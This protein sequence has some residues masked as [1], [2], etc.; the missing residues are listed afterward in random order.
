LLLP[1]PQF[2]GVN[3]INA[4]WG[5]SNYQAM[6]VTLNKRPTH[7]ISFLVAYTWSKW[8]SNVPNEEAQIGAANTNSVQD[9]GN[10]PAEYSLSETDQ[11]LNLVANTIVRLPFGKDAYFLHDLHGL[12]NKLVS[13]WNASAIVL[14][15]SGYPLAFSASTPGLGNRPNLVPNVNPMLPS[16]RSNIQKTQEWFNTAA[17]AIPAPYTLGNMRR[18][19]GDARGPALRNMDFTL[20]KDTAIT[21]RWSMQFRAEAF[22]LTN[23]PHFGLPNTNANATAFG[24]I[25]NTV[26]S[27]EPRQLQFAIKLMF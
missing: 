18:T 22:N 26:T 6:Q 2:T 3:E 12:P 4:T 24:Q 17:F 9:Y 13:G 7:G 20:F 11:P 8:M 1:Y 21:E 27:P 23:T 14:V 10:L 25:T 16:N 15:Q 19:D 5:K